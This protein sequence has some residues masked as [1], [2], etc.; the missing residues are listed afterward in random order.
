MNMFPNNNLNMTLPQQFLNR[1]LSM[2]SSVLSNDMRNTNTTMTTSVKPENITTIYVGKI[3]LNV[4]DTLLK[5]V[6]NL[7][8]SILNW[9]RVVDPITQQPKSF[10]YCDFFEAESALAAILIIPE[11]PIQGNKLVLTADSKNKELI[12]VVER[13]RGNKQLNKSDKKIKDQ[14][15]ITIKAWETQQQILK[16]KERGNP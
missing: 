1:Q 11:C 6:L 10:G 2:A 3:P 15:N 16:K 4:D 14:I 12:K 5:T 9:K 13:K 7:C 8:G